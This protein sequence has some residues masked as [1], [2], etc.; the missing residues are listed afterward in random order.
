MTT[1]IERLTAAISAGGALAPLVERTEG[2]AMRDRMQLEAERQQ[3]EL[4]AP[5][6][7]DRLLATSSGIS[8]ARVAEWREARE[9]QRGAGADRSSGS[10]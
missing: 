4:V 6:G 5:G 9:S 2:R 3:L 1:V 8:Q 10:C 7:A